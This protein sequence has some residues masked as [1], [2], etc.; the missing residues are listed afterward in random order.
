MYI[1]KLTITVFVGPVNL[2]SNGDLTSQVLGF[3]NQ[4]LHNPECDLCTHIEFVIIRCLS[5]NYYLFIYSPN[6]LVK[7]FC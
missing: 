1:K 3:L 6:F 4:H 2:I 5:V 7:Y